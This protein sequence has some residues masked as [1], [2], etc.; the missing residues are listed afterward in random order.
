MEKENKKGSKKHFLNERM[1]R[2]AVISNALFI[3]LTWILFNIASFLFKYHAF[4]TQTS[5][6]ILIHLNTVT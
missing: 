1:S 2:H 6:Q 4:Q 3:H 5:I